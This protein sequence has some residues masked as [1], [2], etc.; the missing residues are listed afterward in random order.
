MLNKDT[1][2]YGLICSTMKIMNPRM[3]LIQLQLVIKVYVTYNLLHTL[4]LKGL[5][6]IG[7]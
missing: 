3:H 2:W 6:V 7:E 4:I 5:L 1:V